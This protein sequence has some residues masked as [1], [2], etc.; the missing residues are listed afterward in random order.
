[1]FVDC[2]DAPVVPD[3]IVAHIDC[4]EGDVDEGMVAALARWQAFCHVL[5][6]RYGFCQ[7]WLNRVEAGHRLQPMIGTG[8]FPVPG[9]PG[10]CSG[11]APVGY[12]IVRD[13]CEDALYRLWYG[14][15]FKC[16]ASRNQAGGAA[17][18]CRWMSPQGRHFALTL[19][20][21]S[22][23]RRP[24]PSLVEELTATSRYL[25][26]LF[27]TGSVTHSSPRRRPLICGLRPIYPEDR[28]PQY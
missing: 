23:Y 21:P 22:K 10:S 9:C 13:F 25:K 16:V 19:H 8:V 24:E 20:G 2:N 12:S 18:A 7:V 4:L 1:M 27:E 5:A 3:A 6:E 17:F 11:N 14:P 28:Y 15:H 26:D